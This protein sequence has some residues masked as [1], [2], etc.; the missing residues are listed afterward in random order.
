[1]YTATEYTA[2]E[3]TATEYTDH[4]EYSRTGHIATRAAR[5][6]TRASSCAPR[7]AAGRRASIRRRHRSTTG[8]RHWRRRR[9]PARRRRGPGDRPGDGAVRSPRVAPSEPSAAGRRPDRTPPARRL[10]AG[11]CLRFRRGRDP[12]DTRCARR[13]PTT[14]ASAARAPPPARCAAGAR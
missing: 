3:Y 4:T 7:R 8:R 9:P 11:R 12:P 10:H 6:V 14:A 2:T 13:G 5:G 1:E